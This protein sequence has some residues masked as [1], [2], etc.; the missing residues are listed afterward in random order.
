[1][2]K[3]SD[4]KDQTIKDLK[5]Q[6]KALTLQN[7]ELAALEFSYYD[8]ACEQKSQAYVLQ[9]KLEKEIKNLQLKN[10]KLSKKV[11]KISKKNKQLTETNNVYKKEN[12]SYSKRFKK[13]EDEIERLLAVEKMFKADIKKLK[14]EKKMA[15][16][17]NKK[18]INKLERKTKTLSLK[19]FDIKNE[20]NSIPEFFD[21]LPTKME[22]KVKASVD[23][24]IEK[25][26]KKKK[27][28]EEEEDEDD[29]EEKI[30]YHIYKAYNDTC[31]SDSN[32]EYGFDTFEEALERA[33]ELKGECLSNGYP[34]QHLG[35]FQ[36]GACVSDWS[37]DREEDGNDDDDLLFE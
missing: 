12:N 27:S 19:L 23:V 15:V 7:E 22:S 2:S 31:T 4:T 5:K 9:K 34:M 28:D 14:K 25:T 1:M 13:Y 35:I 16:V 11:E 29:E 3:K 36:D 6:I 24:P 32:F 30:S 17:N 8:E 26:K 10:S 20:L 37:W 33:E 18:M 21:E